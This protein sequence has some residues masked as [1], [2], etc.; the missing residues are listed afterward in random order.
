[1]LAFGV[2]MTKPLLFKVSRPRPF[3]AAGPASVARWLALWGALAACADPGEP[4]PELTPEPAQVD[5]SQLRPLPRGVFESTAFL[6]SPSDS[7]VGN[8]TAGVRDGVMLKLPWNFC[9]TGCLIEIARRELDAAAARGLSI[10]LAIGDAK[11]IPAEVKARCQ[12]FNFLFR[13]EPQTTCVPWDPKYLEAKLALVR[14][15]GQALDTHPALA[16]VYFTG[17]ASTNGMEGHWRVDRTA[18]TAAGYTPERLLTSY[19]SILDAYRAAFPRTPL[20]FEVHAIF[21]SAEPWR[22]LWDH[23]KASGRVGVAAWW[24]AERLSVTG[25]DTTPIWPIVQEAAEL[26]FSV[27]QTVSSFLSSPYDFS[28]PTLGL[29]YG[30][31]A[32]HDAQD[33]QRAFTDTLDWAEGKA[34]HTSA[35]LARRF[36]VLEPWSQ[37]TAAPGFEARLR[38][39]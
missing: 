6:R 3:S 11:D 32:D 36:S 26:S 10:A 15:L 29:D 9:D 20:A 24:C 22:S 17:A 5:P 23:V 18:F 35:P 13:D 12:T 30:T 19:K 7:V 38:A 33:S 37:D 39:F 4:A 27:C 8:R 14:A 2:R 25:R 21:E 28:N 31:E 34:S 16:Y 1:M